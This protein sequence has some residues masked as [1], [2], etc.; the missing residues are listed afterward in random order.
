MNCEAWIQVAHVLRSYVDTLTWPAVVLI[1]CVIYQSSI[2]ALLPGAK[3]KLNIFGFSFEATIPE[4]ELSINENL[5]GGKLSPEQWQWLKK[6]YDQPFEFVSRPT[7]KEL[8]ILRPLRN[9]ALVKGYPSEGFLADAKS[10]AITT[11]GRLLLK[12]K[13]DK[14]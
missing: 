10:V 12:A 4:I 2:R 3:I 1:I 9:S 7:P 5:R 8:E 14:G 6:L 11:L 13:N